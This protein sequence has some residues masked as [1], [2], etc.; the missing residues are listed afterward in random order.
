MTTKIDDQEK[1]P[2][3]AAKDSAVVV[4]ESEAAIEAP[5]D[6][7]VED[8][9]IDEAVAEAIPTITYEFRSDEIAKSLRKAKKIEGFLIESDGDFSKITLPLGRETEMFEAIGEFKNSQVRAVKPD[10]GKSLFRVLNEQDFSVESIDTLSAIFESAVTERIKDR[11]SRIDEDVEA[12]VQ[13][14]LDEISDA[15]ETMATETI[16]KWMVENRVP[17]ADNVRLKNAER[18]MTNLRE[19]LENVGIEI[20]ADKADVVAEMNESVNEVKSANTLLMEENAR[21]KSEL[22]AGEITRI[23]ESIAEENSFSDVQKDR[24]RELMESAEGDLEKKAG[25]LVETFFSKS[26]PAKT[27]MNE[28]FETPLSESIVVDA[29]ERK[30]ADPMDAVLRFMNRRSI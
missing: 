9:K 2:D 22:R 27:K 24:F 10:A 7:P 30:P 20:P 4:V 28:R 13:S 18:L 21:L 15:V 19:S 3:V 29:P 23:V 12:G 14:R 26:K 16:A 17:I 8:V 25:D 11:L 1:T 6:V 5:A